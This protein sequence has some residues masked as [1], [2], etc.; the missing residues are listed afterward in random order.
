MKFVLSIPAVVA[1]SPA[2]F[3]RAVEPKTTPLGF[4]MKTRPFALRLPEMSDALAPDTRLSVIELAE[5]CTKTTLSPAATL[6]P[7]QLTTARVLLWV[8]RVVLP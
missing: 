4:T 5:G 2:V 6:N 7:C 8:T 3:T 1:N